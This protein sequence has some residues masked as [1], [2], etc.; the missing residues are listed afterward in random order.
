MANGLR[1]TCP[2]AR[3]IEGVHMSAQEQEG[4]AFTMDAAR[5]RLAEEFPEIA[6]LNEGMDLNDPAAMEF[7]GRVA[8]QVG[9]DLSGDRDEEAKEQLDEHEQAMREAA[10]PQDWKA[11]LAEMDH[12]AR[13]EA[14]LE[15]LGRKNNQKEILYDLLVFCETE[16]EESEAEAFLEAHKRFADG[17]HSAHKY[18]FFMQRTGAI[19]EREYDSDG[20]LITDEMRDELR[21]A[22]APEEEIEDLAVEW[23]FI[24]TEAGREAVAH[25][26]P[27]DRTREMLAGQKD[28]RHPTFARLLTFCETPRSLDEITTFL[29]G[30]PGLEKDPRTGVMHMQPSAYIGKLDQAGALTWEGGWKTTPG[31]MEV[32]KGLNFDE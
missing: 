31:G 21:E 25:F 22:G 24:T 30:D 20:V 7:G 4:T 13:V 1:E 27:A 17:Y 2:I 6:S 9:A 18:L 32:L 12:A 5:A 19:E 29:A 14:T 16:R 28:S 26:D 11:K 3:S 10:R 8:S 23:R 15:C